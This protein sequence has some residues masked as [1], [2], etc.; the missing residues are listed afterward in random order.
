MTSPLHWSLHG[1]DR[2]SGTLEKLERTLSTLGR[3]L[4]ATTRDA[5]EFGRAVGTAESP[6]HR[7]GAA[8]TS[9]GGHLDGLRSRLGSMAAVAGTAVAGLVA[10]AGAAGGVLA[11]IG[12][13]SAMASETSAIAF[14]TMLGSATAAKAF[15]S[16]LSDFAERT[17]FELSGLRTSASSLL[18]TGIA[19]KDVIP[20]LTRLG[21][22]TSAMN[23]GAEGIARATYA[24]QQM[25]SSGRVALEELN[26]LTEAG[27][28]I[29][30]ALAAS[31]GKSQAEIRKMVSAGKIPVDSVLA[32]ILQG[33]GRLGT[34]AGLMDKQSRTLTGVLSNFKDKAERTLGDLFAPA[35]PAI[36]RTLVG[37][38]GLIGPTVDRLKSMAGQVTGI[39]KGSDVPARL[40][41][42]LR[43]MGQKILP[44]L[45]DAWNDIVKTIKDNREGL[46]KLGRFIADFVVP[47]LAG[48]LVTGIKAVTVAVQ[49][50]IFWWGHFVD[51]MRF[52]VD[53]ALGAFQVL[54]HGAV[55]AFGWIPG[56][57][58]K[59]KAASKN[60]DEFADSVRAKLDA[61]NGKTVDVHVKVH[62]SDTGVKGLVGGKG[63][64]II[65]AFAE[66]GTPDPRFPALVGEQGP[67]ILYQGTVYPLGPGR[68]PSPVAG[69][70]GD[71]LGVV[72]V[73]H[74]K[75][76]G[77]HLRDEL[78][79]LKRRRGP[80]YQ[81]GL[82]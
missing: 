27:V 46:E 5:R 10:A 22:S 58:D 43:E 20:L 36:E 74:E 53:Q 3:R 54:L 70:A 50:M 11:T 39:F 45:K 24:L 63:I 64:N 66:G 44:V 23:T 32:A 2:L 12:I 76:N 41:T 62:V 57:G 71:I 35:L 13:R 67:E 68:T 21:E 33:K 78:L 55:T 18:A 19:A 40:L 59:L 37:V 75:A 7:L 73:R 81:L 48:T 34:F 29:I 82:A 6:V 28:P 14:E 42:S 69:G 49:T 72:V 56:L 65:Q 17:P 1:D 61:L 26:Q 60:F 80:G 16:D 30:D 15:L 47:F 4:D 52:V 8:S 25:R 77:E 31:M 9:A 38:T 51:A 79:T